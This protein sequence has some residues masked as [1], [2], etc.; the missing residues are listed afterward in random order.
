MVKLWAEWNARRQIAQE[1]QRD[2]KTKGVYT[3]PT[4]DAIAQMAQIVDSHQNPV[5]HNDS[6][7]GD[8]FFHILRRDNDV[9]IAEER[10]TPDTFSDSNL[11]SQAR[12]GPQGQTELTLSFTGERFQAR[13]ANPNI[14]HSTKYPNTTLK[15]FNTLAKAVQEAPKT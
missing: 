1:I 7:T 2:I 5:P 9:L 10:A 4:P 15:V 14:V 3:R 12:I 8:K 13:D 6:L 11:I